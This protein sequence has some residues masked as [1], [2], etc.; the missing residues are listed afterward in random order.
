MLT[1]AALVAEAATLRKESR[2][3]HYRTDFPSR[4]DAGFCRRIFL[5]CTG[6]GGIRSELG[7]N[8]GVTDRTPA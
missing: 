5:E 1:V 3:T 8:T 6:A 7:P 4:D 2:G